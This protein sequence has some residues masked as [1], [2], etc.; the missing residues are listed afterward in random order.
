M[1]SHPLRVIDPIVQMER[2]S[3]F[4]LIEVLMCITLVALLMLPFT[5]VMGSTAQS[6]RLAYIQSTRAILLNSLKSETIPGSPNYV[7]NFTISSMN[8]SIS[9]SGQIIPFMRVVDAT[10]SGAT[11]ALKRTTLFYLYNNSTDATSSARY[12][13]TVVDYPK[14]YRMRF[15]NSVDVI[16]SLNRY[17]YNDNAGNLLYSGTNMVPGWTGTHWTS[18]YWS[19][20]ILNTSGNDEYIFQTETGG[21]TLDYSLDVE[22]GAYTVK[23]YFCETNSGNT[24]T[25]RGMNVWL[26]GSQVNTDGPYSPYASTGGANLA[27]VKMYDTVVSDGV[28]NIRIAG[29]PGGT[30]TN[31]NPHAIEVIKRTWL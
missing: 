20:D 1:A 28:L 2:P 25:K 27:E 12:R 8:T 13:T 22:N 24:G 21:G 14:V 19:N 23:I 15:G 7:T 31:A 4:S 29:D 10:T 17:W 16:D 5:M 26:E 18:N 6:A 9:D 11:N 3:G 30:D